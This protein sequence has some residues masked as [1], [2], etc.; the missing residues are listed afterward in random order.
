LYL[1][2]HHGTARRECRAG[3]QQAPQWRLGTGSCWETR[4]QRD[5]SL[6]DLVRFV[7]RT[8][9]VRC[10]PVGNSR[11]IGSLAAASNAVSR[12]NGTVAHGRENNK[13]SNFTH[14]SPIGVIG[15][16]GSALNQMPPMPPMPPMPSTADYERDSHVA[17]SVEKL[18]LYAYAKGTPRKRACGAAEDPLIAFAR[19]NHLAFV[20]PTM[21]DRDF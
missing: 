18:F 6:A 5:R 13:Q 11:R 7:V 1:G 19:R 14:P 2:V 16:V 3:Q 4:Q 21:F 12:R 17:S 9:L 10:Q 15:G 8:V 20:E